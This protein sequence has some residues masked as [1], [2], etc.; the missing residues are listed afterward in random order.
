MRT[1]SDWM[2]MSGLVLVSWID[3]RW[4]KIPVRLLLIFSIITIGYQLYCRPM[5]WWIVAG[6]IGIGIVFFI[7]SK[8]TRE[9]IGYADS[10]MILN[11]GIYQGFW[12]ILGTL[13]GAM[14]ILGVVSL[15]TVVLKQMSRKCV[16]PFVPFL[17]A[18]YFLWILSEV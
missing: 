4:R 2:L 13:T 15:I 11:L 14:F 9:S 6:G 7:I 18:G 10:W 17:T 12:G 5:A 16:L 1:V 8:K 3:I